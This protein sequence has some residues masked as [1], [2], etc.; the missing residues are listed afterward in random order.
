MTLMQ[1]R[2]R[3]VQSFIVRIIKES[4]YYSYAGYITAWKY[5]NH[6]T[7]LLMV[8]QVDCPYVLSP[9][10]NLVVGT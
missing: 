4:C 9:Q 7:A 10:A 1:E 6:S 2:E 5:P 3:N 8:S